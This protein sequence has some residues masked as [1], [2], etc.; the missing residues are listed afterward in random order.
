M[1]DE[2]IPGWHLTGDSPAAATPQG[3]IDRRELAFI[4]VE[5]TRMP[6]VVSDPR[7]PD[8]PIVL[9][10]QAF[11]DLCGYSAGEVLGRNC[12]FLQ[13]P[14]TSRDAVDEIRRGLASGGDVTVELLNYRR[15]GTPFRNELFISP[16]HDERGEL[17]YHFASQKDV[18]AEH[19]VRER[20]A[21][22]LRLMREV[23]HRAKNVLALV[24]GIVR[25]SRADTAERYA[26]AVQGRVQAL[27]RA[28][29]M[30]S[31]LRWHEVPLG[32]LI[33]AE[34]EPFGAERILLDGPELGLPA[35]LVQPIALLVY[36]LVSNAVDHGALLANA[37][38]VLVGWHENKA[39]GRLVI[40]WRETG[41][42]APPEQRV[43]GFGL[44]MIAA[45]VER[46][47]RGR[48]VLD[49]RP[50]G[51]SGEFFVP[52]HRPRTTEAESSGSR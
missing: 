14:D 52:L 7:Q 20:R 1:S 34:V 29:A 11:L 13:G 48:T 32:K 12:R 5:R 19:E 46:Q 25:M 37:G 22:E 18:T 24:Q 6:M 49:W 27:A 38:R 21:A 9:A 28:H 3:L 31:E 44:T 36:E 15:N 50:D 30:L 33:E 41:G 17:L 40:R 42:P 4:A 10:N 47:L 26:A 43:P 51:L 23:D 8:N 16:V 39:A 45:I 35:T 2:P